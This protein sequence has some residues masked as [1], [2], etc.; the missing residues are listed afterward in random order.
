MTRVGMSLKITMDAQ[1]K[2]SLRVLPSLA[3]RVRMLQ[4]WTVYLLAEQVRKQVLE[5]I[6]KDR[7][8]QSY[9]RSLKT[10]RLL[11]R[12]QA[13][14]VYS[15]GKAAGV[16]EVDP[17]CTVVFVRVRR[18][19]LSRPPP[20][21]L[22][23]Q[24]YSPWTLDTIPFVPTAKEARVVSREVTAPIVRAV[25]EA[26]QKDE[27]QWRAELDRAGSRVSRSDRVPLPKT[28]GK[29][30]PDVAFAGLRLEFGM[31]GARAQPH[32]SPAM[33]S[34]PKGLL[35]AALHRRTDVVKLLSDPAS[36]SW[37]RLIPHLPPLRPSEAAKFKHFQQ[38]IRGPHR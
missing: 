32:W 6:P 34:A 20:Q 36:G 35:R 38:R 18:K 29:P 11:S 15:D 7:S 17:A 23:L 28:P 2:R 3:A 1:S 19:G 4:R 12:H 22:I 14:A 26:R 21:V 24:R 10:A 16:S 31:G 30:L 8:L 13:F 33:R 5:G 9:R 37:R 27:P 25:A